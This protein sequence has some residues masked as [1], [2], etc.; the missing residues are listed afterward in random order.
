MS[1]SSRPRTDWILGGLLL[2]LLLMSLAGCASS[3]AVVP[4][5]KAKVP[6]EWSEKQLPSAKAYSQKVSDFLQRVQSYQSET[7][8]FTMPSHQP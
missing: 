6:V 7:P 4:C 8:Q 3:P 5:E 2:T 1:G